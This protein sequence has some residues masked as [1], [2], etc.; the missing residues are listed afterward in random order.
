MDYARLKLGQRLYGI[1]KNLD[2]NALAKRA[3]QT[4]GFSAAGGALGLFGAR[5]I[6]GIN[7]IVNGRIVREDF[8]DAY[9]DK[10]IADN[11][12]TTINQQ[13]DDANI[14]S[15]LNLHPLHLSMVIKQQT[16]LICLQHNRRLK[17]LND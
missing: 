6:K 12:V 15:Q 17:E 7:N 2:D 13:L 9:A 8:L 16:T 3:F 11:V 10:T 5:G 4:G 14:K 1:N